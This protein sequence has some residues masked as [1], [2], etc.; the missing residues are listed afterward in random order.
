MKKE[1]LVVLTGAGISAESGLQTFRDADGLWENYQIEDVATPQAWK[2]NPLLV[3]EFYNKRRKQILE[4]QPNSGH[5]FLQKLEQ[6]YD[7]HIITQNID[8]LHERAF[9]K[10][11]TH[12]HGNIRFAKSSGPNQEKKLYPID[13]WE[14]KM[15]DLCDD[16]FTLRPHVVWFGEEVPM[17]DQ[18]IEICQTADILL[19]IGTSLQVYPAASLVEFTKKGCKKII[20]DP[21]SPLL[22]STEFT[23]IQKNITQAITDLRKELG[24]QE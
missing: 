19:V 20:V 18:A 5:L 9:S 2:K 12:L 14:L 13:S 22:N 17:M 3:Q 16:G 10:N 15:T 21:N 23:T 11:I 8:D 6:F 1:S 4:A 24:I 7:V